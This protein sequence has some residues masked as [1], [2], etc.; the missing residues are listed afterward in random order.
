MAALEPSSPSQAL[1]YQEVRGGLGPSPQELRRQEHQWGWRAPHR[2]R[3]VPT[4]VEANY[5]QPWLARLALGTGLRA[6]PAGRTCAQNQHR[7]VDH[8]AKGTRCLVQNYSRGSSAVPQWFLKTTKMWQTRPD[9]QADW[10]TA[11]DPAVPRACCFA[12]QRAN[13]H[14][15]GG[16]S[17]NSHFHK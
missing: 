16:E 15:P 9:H 7:A 14:Q 2:Q 10:S 4:G 1:G 11:A 12:S 3:P 13:T 6:P 17:F 5:P 8:R